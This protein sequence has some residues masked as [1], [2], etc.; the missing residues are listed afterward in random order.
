[1]KKS[2]SSKRLSNIELFKDITQNK[3]AAKSLLTE[4]KQMNKELKSKHFLSDS[5]FNSKEFINNALKTGLCITE[6]NNIK[7]HNRIK[8]REMIKELKE[9]AKVKY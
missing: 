7:N 6:K 4:I 9:N 5:K 3:K 1:M 8:I 2:I